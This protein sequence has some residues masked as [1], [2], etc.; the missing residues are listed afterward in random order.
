[1]D[2]SSCSSALIP[3][4]VEDSRTPGQDLRIA[5]VVAPLLGLGELFVAGSVRR[6]PPE[7]AGCV[8]DAALSRPAPPRTR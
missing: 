8:D 7:T 4:R 3:D 2:V 1:M 5:V 6:D